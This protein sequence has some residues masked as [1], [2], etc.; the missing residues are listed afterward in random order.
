MFT[1]FEG[2]H[3]I[4]DVGLGPITHTEQKNKICVVAILK[5]PIILT[6]FSVYF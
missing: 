3:I 4:R 1:F 5:P 2:T 6:H